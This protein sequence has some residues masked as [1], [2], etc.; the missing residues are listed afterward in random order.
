[1]TILI[2]SLSMA[3][4]VRILLPLLFQFV[5][6]RKFSLLTHK[7]L[8]HYHFSLL[9]CKPRGWHCCLDFSKIRKKNRNHYQIYM[10]NS[11]GGKF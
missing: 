2:Y 1:M 10:A 6:H 11:Y 7:P 3:D 5:N 4:I 8:S 9:V